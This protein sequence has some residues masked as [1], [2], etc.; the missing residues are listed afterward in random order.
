MCMRLINVT[1]C[2]F[3]DTGENAN[4]DLLLQHTVEDED[5][6]SLQ[7]VEDSEEVG[8]HHCALVDVHEAESPG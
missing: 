2:Y 1:P 6:H 3:L 5:E 8:H 4:A 7:G